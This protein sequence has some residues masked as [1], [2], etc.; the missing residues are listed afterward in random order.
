MLVGAL[1]V[2]IG[3]LIGG[4]LT[5]SLTARSDLNRQA[6]QLTSLREQQRRDAAETP[7][8]DLGTTPDLD[9]GARAQLT[10][11]LAA[12][13]EADRAVD[14]EISTWLRGDTELSQV[15]KALG[16]CMFR[17]D[18]YDRLAARFAA[19]QLAGLPSAIDLTADA[20]DCGRATID[21]RAKAGSL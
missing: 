9:A 7:P 4:A 12:V 14:T 3:L 19:A 13:R 1:A 18:S 10:S 6:V 5:I 15:W 16:R 8:P 2:L 11:D 20:T 17:V 21:R